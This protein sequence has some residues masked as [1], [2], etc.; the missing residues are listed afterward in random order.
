MPSDALPMPTTL[1]PLP[2]PLEPLASLIRTWCQT[3]PTVARAFLYGST[4]KG[5]PDPS[6]LDLA[7]QYVMP[8]YQDVLD[9]L[10]GELS[11]W[12]LELSAITDLRVDLNVAHPEVSDRVWS[13]LDQGC[14]LVFERT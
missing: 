6:D 8:A 13:Y 3:K 1:M 2:A 4:L 14:A 7:V 10:V 11:R 5:K 9:E 12:E